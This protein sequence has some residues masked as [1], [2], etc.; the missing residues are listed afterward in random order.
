MCTLEKLPSTSEAL[1]LNSL[2]H[3]GHTMHLSWMLRLSTISAILASLC[4]LSSATPT[5]FTPARDTVIYEF[6]AD[7]LS[8]PLR[9]LP[10]L[11]RT[12][13]ISKRSA[14]NRHSSNLWGNGWISRSNTYVSPPLR[15]PHSQKKRKKKKETLT[16]QPR[17][18]PS[19]PSSPP[20]PGSPSSTP[21]SCSSPPPSRPTCQPAAQQS[22]T[23]WQ[24]K[25]CGFS[26]AD[27]KSGSSA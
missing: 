26:S 1:P 20:P 5:S 25:W 15:T 12:Q 6:N 22:S 21:A 27:S 24:D 16:P 9:N 4:I 23:A 17:S 3:Y 14:L 11:P 2:P 18:W 10:A 7:A 13:S 8:G 19:S